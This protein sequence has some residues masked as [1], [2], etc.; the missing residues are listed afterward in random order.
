MA[1]LDRAA[2]LLV[3]PSLGDPWGLVVNEAFACGLPVVC[4]RL[5]GCADDLLEP[6]RNGWLFDPTD[7]TDA[8]QVLTEALRSRDLETMGAHACDTVKRFGPETMA[9]GFRQAILHA[10]APTRTR[11]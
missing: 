2:D 10:T 3:F 4:S 1:E 7:P 11:A 6:G 5:A 8:V 9:E